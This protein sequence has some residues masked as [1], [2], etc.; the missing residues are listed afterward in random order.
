M[1]ATS[2]TRWPADVYRFEAAVRRT[3]WAWLGER[4]GAVVARYKARRTIRV[5]SAL[6]DGQ[7][8]DIGLFRGDIERVAAKTSFSRR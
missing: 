3:A 2:N 5:L 4:V 7:L 1:N 6:S 8:R